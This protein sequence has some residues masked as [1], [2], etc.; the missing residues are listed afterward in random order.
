MKGVIKYCI[1][2]FFSLNL[3]KTMFYIL[4]YKRVF[5]VF[6]HT[7]VCL[8]KASKMNIRK[9]LQIGVV[10]KG[11]NYAN[12]TTFLVKKGGKISV[13]D[14]TIHSG[15]T[16]VVMKNALLTMGSGY[17]NR[18][19]TIVCSKEIT[20]GHDVAIAQN[21]VIRDSDIHTFIEEPNKE[22][23][24]TLPIKIG[25][26]VWIGTNSIILKGVEIGDN[27]VIAAGSIVTRN[28]PANS[29]AAGNPAKV[30]KTNID[31]KK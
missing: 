14:F 22:R 25:N 4:T 29:L 27:A 21:V 3:C 18:N 6:K 30:I 17:V 31:W 28:V 11:W 15:S 19:T 16:V 20:I 12:P 5:F 13:G 26:H 9:R 23:E 1:D 8:Q 10:W 24:N 7:S 2:N